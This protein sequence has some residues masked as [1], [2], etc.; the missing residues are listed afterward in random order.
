MNIA[1]IVFSPPPEQQQESELFEIRK[2]IYPRAV[3]GPRVDLL[4]DLEQLAFLL[5]LRRRAEDDRSDIHRSRA[6][7]NRT[8]SAARVD[9]VPASARRSLDARYKAPH[10]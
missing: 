5:L 3:H 2:K 1:P 8:R 9:P 7:A 10:I 6:F 4:P